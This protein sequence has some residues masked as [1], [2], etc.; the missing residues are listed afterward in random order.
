MFDPI[1]SPARRPPGTSSP[2][3]VVGSVRSGTSAVALALSQG[4]G[5]PH[6]E[7]GHITTLLRMVFDTAE[8]VAGNFADTQ[9]RFLINE[10]DLNAFR[11]HV[12]NF[13]F[14][15]V[16][17]RYP[18]GMWMDKTPDDFARSP[19]I[20]AAPLMLDFFPNARFIYCVRRGV[21]NVLSRQRKFPETP[22]Y[23]HCRSWA[24]SVMAWEAV[25]PLLGNRWL[26]ARQE[27]LSL[28]PEKMAREIADFLELEDAKRLAVEHSLRTDRPEQSR[29]AADFRQL[30]LHETGWDDACIAI[31]REECSEAMKLAGYSLDGEN[32][33]ADEGLAL[34]QPSAE[35]PAM[36]QLSGLQPDRFQRLGRFTI[37]FGPPPPGQQARFTYSDLV[38][39][40]RRRFSAVLA[41]EGTSDA[42]VRFG[43]EIRDWHGNVMASTDRVVG[44]ADGEVPMELGIPEYPNQPVSVTITT[45]FIAGSYDPEVKATWTRPAFYL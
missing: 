12:S 21:E 29:P 18:S 38:L 31:F 10:L 1:L 4:A 14:A 44:A 24:A 37:W 30:G 6:H 32:I 26:E 28:E 23:Y 20:R 16:E 40:G 43:V 27:Q 19:A 45:E 13:L 9:G 5:L 25:R 33:S 22:F 42:Q 41:V 7:E 36:K 15:F 11:T 17:S 39:G 34:F 3:F 2:V 35:G 8:E